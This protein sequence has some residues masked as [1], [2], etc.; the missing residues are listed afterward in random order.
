MTEGPVKYMD[1][2]YASQYTSIR[3]KV[4]LLAT[5]LLA[6][7]R[8]LDTLRILIQYIAILLK[9]EVGPARLMGASSDPDLLFE[10]MQTVSIEGQSL[11]HPVR[12]PFR[13]ATS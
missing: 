11:L 12:C 3:Q 1:R 10:S 6:L 7:G 2:K 9:M 5:V 4:N 13:V 8:T